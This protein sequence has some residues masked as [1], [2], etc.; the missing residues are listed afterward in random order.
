[1]NASYNYKYYKYN[2]LNTKYEACDAALLRRTGNIPPRPAIANMTKHRMARSHEPRRA[3][4]AV[5][6]SYGPASIYVFDVRKNKL[7][8]C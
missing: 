3:E 2:I 1:M 5:A 4:N 7:E 6:D 8:N